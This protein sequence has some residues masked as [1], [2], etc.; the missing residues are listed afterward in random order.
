M[1]CT[2][3]RATVKRWDTHTKKLKYFSSA[4]FDEYKN[5]FGKG[6]SPRSELMTG[7]NISTFPISKIYL[8]DHHFI[9]D[10]I[11]EV[12]VNLPPR[13]TP[14]SIIAQYCEH[15]NISYTDQSTNNIPWDHDFLEINRANFGILS[16]VRKEPTAAQKVLE[17]IS[18][19]Q[20]TGKS[21]RVN[22][23]NFEN[24]YP[25]KW[26]YIQSNQTYTSNRKQTNWSSYKTS[27]TR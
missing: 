12:N 27:N 3:S 25:R 22:V 11:F 24:K 8:S 13:G 2:S 14:I 19:K 1:G 10:I 7:T 9:K 17:D 16:T 21:N 26:I 15:N 23:I 6:W 20:I 18:S 4:K 5:K